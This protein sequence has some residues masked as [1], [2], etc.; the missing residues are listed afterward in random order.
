M[1]GAAGRGRISI[2]GRLRRECRGITIERVF[3]IQERPAMPWTLDYSPL[4]RTI[5]SLEWLV[6]QMRHE[7]ESST[8]ITPADYRAAMVFVERVVNDL[9]PLQELGVQERRV[10][11]KKWDR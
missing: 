10:S 2:C 9:L 6:T 7:L 8:E 3:S 1:I 5:D 11:S 4:D